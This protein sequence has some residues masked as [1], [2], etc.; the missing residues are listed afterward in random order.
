VEQLEARTLLAAGDL[1]LSFGPAGTGKVTPLNFELEEGVAVVIQPSDGKIVVAETVR[2]EGRIL[3]AVRR[4][5]V[6]GSPDCSFGDF[7][8]CGVSPIGQRLYQ[9]LSL[10]SFAHDVAI[11]HGTGKILL[12]ATAQGGKGFL[13]FRLNLDGSGDPSFGNVTGGISLIEFPDVNASAS[14]IAIQPDGRIVVS[15][16]AFSDAGASMAVARLLPNGQLDSEFDADGK[17]I[18]RIGDSAVGSDV[19]IQ[20]DG[21]IVVVGG[22]SLDGDLFVAAARYNTDGSLDTSFSRDGFPRFA[23]ATSVTIQP[24]QKILVAGTI[25]GEE[26]LHFGLG[27]LQTDGSPDAS[28]GPF[29]S[30]VVETDFGA[31]TGMSTTD[32]ASSVALMSNGKIVVAGR[33]TFGGSSKNFAIARYHASGNL[34]FSFSSDGLVATDFDGEFDEA[35]GVAIDALGRVVAVG[36]AGK[37]LALARYLP[38]TFG[39]WTLEFHGPSGTSGPSLSLVGSDGP[40]TIQTVDLGGGEIELRTVDGH[41]VETFNGIE[42]IMVQGNGG[43]DFCIQLLDVT[44]SRVDPTRAPL[45]VEFNGG[46]G[47]DK[48]RIESLNGAKITATVSG[49]DGSRRSDPDPHIQMLDSTSAVATDVYSFETEILSLGLGAGDDTVNVLWDALQFV[50]VT[51]LQV[52]TGAGDDR[53][54][55]MPQPIMDESRI[56]PNPPERRA[57]EIVINSGDG[58]DVVSAGFDHPYALVA[59]NPQ[60]DPPIPILVYTIDLGAGDDQADVRFPREA[61]LDLPTTIG[62]NGGLGNDAVAVLAE[63]VLVDQPFTVTLDGSLGDDDL[64]IDFTGD[65]MVNAPTAMNLFGAAGADKMGIRLN[66]I[67]NATVAVN[68][69]G[70]PDGDDME[71]TFEGEMNADYNVRLAAGD[72]DDQVQTNVSGIVTGSLAI[73]ADL[74]AG[75]NMAALTAEDL[76]LGGERG[77]FTA[78]T[79]GGTGADEVG[80]V[81]INNHVGPD[82]TMKWSTDLGNGTNVLNLTADGLVLDG[83]QFTASSRDGTGADE[84]GIIVVN[85][86]VGPDSPMMWSTDLGNGT[87][88]LNLTADGLVLDGGQFTASS[89]GGTGADEVGIIVVNSHVG[90]DSPMMWSTELGN[91]VNGYSQIFDGLMLTGTF[92]SSYR[93]GTASDFVDLQLTDVGIGPVGS[94]NVDVNASSGL[95]E[96]TVRAERLMV[97]GSLVGKLRGG[98]R[99]DIADVQIYEGHVG[100]DG[101]LDLSVDLFGG[102]NTSHFGAEDFVIDG[103]AAVTMRGGVRQDTM[104]AML[105]RGAVAAG[106]SLSLMMLGNSG[107]NSLDTEIFDLALDGEMVL[108]MTGGRNADTIAASVQLASRSTGSLAADL[109]G[110][111]GN[112]DLFF[113][114]L[115][116]AILRIRRSLLDGGRGLDTCH[117]TGPAR[118]I[119]C[120]R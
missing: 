77:Q 51:R 111:A 13:V 100:R 87:N 18:T 94:A 83:G 90:P 116:P 47:V 31:A 66:D 46:E 96:M 91:G 81:V 37:R 33:T 65:V 44:G 24:D 114:L 56:P 112:D 106:G 110:D 86:H 93:G 73:T 74:G 30:G 32:S 103:R 48:V 28:F 72:G 2:S 41:A 23:A 99:S 21:R 25:V 14:A 97:D 71:F 4:F 60:P 80:I 55:V 62:V 79:R 57:I 102:P 38:N 7:G 26:S 61:M 39:E 92:S 6:N 16:T 27:R 29:G 12:A 58:D 82:S 101:S 19:A 120:E 109:R 5:N 8:I 76:M 1:D 69:D 98:A 43:D 15:G 10:Q 49:D 22:A 59:F 67:V 3:A 84:V 85:S 113:D 17:V 34:D 68:M 42:A 50:D 40:D 104:S 52:D 88:V 107:A 64:G 89:R 54:S 36:S 115:V 78:S 119:G 70:G 45:R 117:V 95:N 35:S 108:G 118:V 20:D 9:L 11:E 75:Q 53:V 63:A 105:T